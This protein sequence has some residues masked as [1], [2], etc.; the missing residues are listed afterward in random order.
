MA[1]ELQKVRNE[2]EI[3]FIESSGGAFEIMKDGKLIYS[4]LRQGSFP[5]PGDI[6]ERLG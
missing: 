4:K 2:I 3:E 6:L 5:D 1:E